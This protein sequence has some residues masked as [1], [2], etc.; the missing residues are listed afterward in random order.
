MLNEL[1]IVER[2]TRDVMETIQRHPDIKDA[3]RMPTVLVALD[4]EGQ[5]ASV[6]PVPHEA[7]IW[8]LRD[9]QHNSFPF[10]QPRDPLWRIPQNPEN[11]AG[12]ALALEKES[13]SRRKALLDLAA[14]ALF[15]IEAFD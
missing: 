4:Y 3:R 13:T 10:I 7:T 6:R 1:V 14:N 9:G 5:V 11:D 12:R 15:N 8:T 2:G